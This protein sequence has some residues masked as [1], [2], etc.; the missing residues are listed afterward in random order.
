M[1]KA[2]HREGAVVVAG[3]SEGGVTVA[4]GH[5][6]PAA[7]RCAQDAPPAGVPCRR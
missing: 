2:D 5:E 7:R 1:K 6:E 3:R 4:A